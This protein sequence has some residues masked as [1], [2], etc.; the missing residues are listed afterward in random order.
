M[1]GIIVTV[2]HHGWGAMSFTWNNWGVYVILVAG[3]IVLTA[4][5]FYSARWPWQYI[6]EED[7]LVCRPI[8]GKIFKIAWKDITL[9]EDWEYKKGGH[10]VRIHARAKGKEDYKFLIWFALDDIVDIFEA[11]G[12]QKIKMKGLAK[13]FHDPSIGGGYDQEPGIPW[14]CKKCNQMNEGGQKCVKCQSYRT[15]EPIG[16]K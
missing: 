10:S 8:W 3:D 13:Y 15:Q 11:F 9:V 1:Y 16:M 12:H 7:G 5:Y 2:Y 6:I 14:I 4:M